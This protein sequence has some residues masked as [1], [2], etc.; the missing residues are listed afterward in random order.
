[1]TKILTPEFLV[2]EYRSRNPFVIA[3]AL[4][5]PVFHHSHPESGLAVCSMMMGHNLPVIHINSAFFSDDEEGEDDMLQVGAHELGH[6]INDKDEMRK[7]GPLMEYEIFNV[8]TVREVNANKFSARIRIDLDE[9]DDLV[10]SGYDY[11]QLARALHVNVNLILYR[12][13]DLNEEKGRSINISVH[14]D[15]GFMGSFHGAGTY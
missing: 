5:I 12:L 2:A 15:S 4:N 9:L 10:H 3:E 11:I 6:A 8:K 1:M 14:P 13:Q 7:N